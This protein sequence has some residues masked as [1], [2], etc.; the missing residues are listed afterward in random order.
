MIKLLQ[1]RK[2]ASEIV[3]K[4]IL[5]LLKLVSLAYKHFRDK[6]TRN[7]ICSLTNRI[8]TM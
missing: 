5:V 8:R 2:R 6:P 3:F 1:Y 4:I 7:I